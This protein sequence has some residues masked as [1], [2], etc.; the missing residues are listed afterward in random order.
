V[1]VDQ[2]LSLKKEFK[3]STGVDW[4]PDVDITKLAAAT[5][6]EKAGKKFET[7]APTEHVEQREEVSS[8]QIAAAK[9]AWSH[10]SK[11]V[12]TKNKQA[13]PILPKPD[14]RNILVTS[15]LPYVKISETFL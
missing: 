14:K 6:G 3:T 8:E 10:P 7:A 9:L 1:T 12:V 2:L 13:A 4:K 15:A 5:G 11:E